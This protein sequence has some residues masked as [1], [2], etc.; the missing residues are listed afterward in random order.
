MRWAVIIANVVL[1]MVFVACALHLAVIA[2]ELVIGA[3]GALAPK[4]LLGVALSIFG[5]AGIMVAAAV[6]SV[7]MIVSARVLCDR[8]LFVGKIIMITSSAVCILGMGIYG[9]RIL[10]SLFKF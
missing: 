4:G 5:A 9:T 6:M 10:R 3:Q 8:L 1:T 2:S 7:A